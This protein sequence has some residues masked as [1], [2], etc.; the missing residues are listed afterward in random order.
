MAHLILTLIGEDRP[1]LVQSVAEVVSAHAGN[2]ERSQLAHLAGQ[3]AGLVE[4]GVDND[5]ADDLV[6]ALRGLEGLEVTLRTGRATEAPPPARRIVLDLVGNDRLG[7]V[8]DV[9]SA[10]AARGAN[11]ERLETTTEEAPMAGGSI[12]RARVEA[13]VVDRAELADL[14]QAL[15][16]LAGELMV[17]LEVTDADPD[18]LL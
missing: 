16:D 8:A 10:L 4:V 5:Q 2:W 9:T 15:E 17:D 3:F 11:I 1:G 6:A 12:F 18:S 13:S 7:I 14:T